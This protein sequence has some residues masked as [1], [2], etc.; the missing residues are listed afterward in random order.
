MVFIEFIVNKLLNLKLISSSKINPTPSKIDWKTLSTSQEDYLI[1]KENK[2]N[3]D[4]AEFCKNPNSI[5]LYLKL[6]KDFK[7]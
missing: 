4:W 5:E 1:L 3:I 7:K 6:Q 2:Y